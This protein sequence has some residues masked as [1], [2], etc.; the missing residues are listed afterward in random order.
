ML[1]F[2]SSRNNESSVEKRK[3][4]KE[5]QIYKEKSAIGVDSRCQKEK[6]KN[7]CFSLI[8]MDW[9][10]SLINNSQLALL[11]TAME[12]HVVSNPDTLETE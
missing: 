4:R 3:G 5:K 7:T 2:G 12:C 1:F 10:T 6:K 11:K 8:K 9:D